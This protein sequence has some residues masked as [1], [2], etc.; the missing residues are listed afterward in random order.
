[1]VA[2]SKTHRHF[3]VGGFE[4]RASLVDGKREKGRKEEKRGRGASFA[5]DDRER[6]RRRKEK[7]G[8]RKINDIRISVIA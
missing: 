7:K 2:T 6:T 1:M 4:R 3:K 8:E 5:R